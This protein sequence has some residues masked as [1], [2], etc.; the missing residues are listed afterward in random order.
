MTGFVHPDTDPQRKHLQPTAVGHRRRLRRATSGRGVDGA[1][2]TSLDYLPEH[3][4]DFAFASL[5]EQRGFLGAA[6]PAAALPARRLARAEGRRRRAGRVLGDRRR[7][8]RVR[9]PVPDLR[10]RRDDDRDRAGDGHPVAVRQRR[11]LLDGRQ[12]ARD[13]RA[14]GDLRARAR[15]R[16]AGA[17]VVPKPS[18]P[19]RPGL[20]L[21]ILG[22]LRTAAKKDEPLVVSGTPELASVLRGCGPGA[23][24]RSRSAIRGCS[25]VRGRRSSTWSSAARRGRRGGLQGGLAAAEFRS[26]VVVAGPEGGGHSRTSRTRTSSASGVAPASRSRGSRSR[27]RRCSASRARARRRPRRAAPRGLRGARPQVLRQQRVGRRGVFVP[28]ADLPVLTLNQVRLVRR[29]ADAYGVEVDRQRALEVPASSPLGSGS[30]RS[31]AVRSA[32]VPVIGR[33]VKPPLPSPARGL[34]AR[35]RSGTSSAARP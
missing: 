17:L 15:P 6:V 16:P 28:G 31:P 32:T 23:G 30:A 18:L 1:T 7:R 13:R 4:T 27:S 9:A 11:R 3:A 14:P 2:Q 5:A 10:Q 35:R 20:I 33:A 22:E 19:V 21:G 34:S 25:R 12:P 29:I 26:L 8:D 24:C